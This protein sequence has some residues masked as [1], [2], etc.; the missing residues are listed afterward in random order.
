MLALQACDDIDGLL[1]VQRAFACLEKLIA[2]QR[3][4]ET[5]ELYPTRTELGALVGVVNE[6]LHRRLA[7]ADATLQS[8]RASLAQRAVDHHATPQPEAMA[9]PG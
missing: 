6:E 4:S 5:D 2:P 3:T 7:A 8:L 1:G 9:Q